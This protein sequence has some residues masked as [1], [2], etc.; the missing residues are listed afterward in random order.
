M[1]IGGQ[2]FK[3]D[4][5]IHQDGRIQDN[6]WRTSGHHLLKVQDVPHMPTSLNFLAPKNIVGAYQ[7]AKGGKDDE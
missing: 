4:L 6:W 7:A 2:E 3:A 1:T 5:I